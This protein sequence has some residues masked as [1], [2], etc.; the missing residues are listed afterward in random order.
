MGR[1]LTAL[2]LSALDAASQFVLISLTFVSVFFHIVSCVYARRRLQEY[3]D[4]MEAVSHYF[5]SKTI[6]I[7][8]TGTYCIY[9]ISSRI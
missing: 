4:H 6:G 8:C 9:N 7:H 1:I 3:S 2:G 5:S